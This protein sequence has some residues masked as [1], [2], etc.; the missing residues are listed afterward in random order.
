MLWAAACLCF[1]GFLRSGEVTCPSETVF[2]P[3]THLS[4][5]DVTVSSRAAPMAIQ[6][7]IKASKTDPFRQGGKVYIGV[8]DGP[9]CP[10]AAVLSFMVARGSSELPYSVV[11]I[12]IMFCS[13]LGGTTK[14]QHE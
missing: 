7:T 10:V 9:L 4:F 5:K 14:C 2:D 11:Y 6:V 1:A 13:F 3:Q 8:A 12:I